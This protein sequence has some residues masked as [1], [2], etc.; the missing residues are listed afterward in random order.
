MV[1]ELTLQIQSEMN[2]STDKG[3]PI[4]V[5]VVDKTTFSV[6]AFQ[7]Y[8]NGIDYFNDSHFTE[9]IIE[10]KNAISIDSTF[11]NAYYKL[12]LAQWWSQSEMDNESIKNA[13]K[14][15]QKILNGSWYRT[16]KEK[17][18]AQGALELT[19]QNFIKA[20]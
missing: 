11:S 15:L 3:E 4:D 14:S 6:N 10:F 18:L 20:E 2:I 12:A 7:Y 19:N 17:L 8:F 5:A 13:Q 1:D 9:A 16:T